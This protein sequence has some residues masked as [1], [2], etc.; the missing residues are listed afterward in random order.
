MEINNVKNRNQ[1]WILKINQE[2][3]L[4]LTSKSKKKQKQI[5]TKKKKNTYIIII[6][7]AIV[8]LALSGD[9]RSNV[10]HGTSVKVRCFSCFRYLLVL[11]N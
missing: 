11:Y 4:N 10:R 3:S 6:A 7:A 5:I 9:E 2:N 8:L 1:I